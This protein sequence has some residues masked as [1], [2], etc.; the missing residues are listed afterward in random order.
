[1]GS[2]GEVEYLDPPRAGVYDEQLRFVGREG[3]DLR[4]TIELAGRISA[5][6]V[7]IYAFDIAHGGCVVTCFA[8]VR[9]VAG[10]RPAASG[11]PTEKRCERERIRRSENR[12]STE[13][14]VVRCT[15]QHATVARRSLP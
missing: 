2:L 3:D 12:A 6:P 10:P 7:E 13:S 4:A 8:T 14:T 15:V 9:L 5:D 1:M 11:R